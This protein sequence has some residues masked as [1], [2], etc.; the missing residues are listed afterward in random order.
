MFV[1]FLQNYVEKKNVF[2]LNTL[3]YKLYVACTKTFLTEN[4]CFY[5]KQT[6]LKNMSWLNIFFYRKC[7]WYRYKYLPFLNIISFC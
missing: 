4:N 6:Y 1:H 7:M 2:F 3:F 5:R